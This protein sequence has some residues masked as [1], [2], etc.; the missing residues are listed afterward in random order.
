MTS[1][2]KKLNEFEVHL[3]GETMD[4]SRCEGV[5]VWETPFTTLNH[6]Q[7]TCVACKTY[8]RNP[9]RPPAFPGQTNETLNELER[10]VVDAAIKWDMG[11]RN[12]GNNLMRAVDALRAAKDEYGT[13]AYFKKHLTES[14]N[15]KA[16]RRLVALTLI[17]S[18]ITANDI[19]GLDGVREISRITSVLAALTLVNE[20]LQ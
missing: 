15:T 12:G 17:K 13:V 11:G 6:D 16:G 5:P 7:V 1:E 9:R 20:A 3:A 8:P 2:T 10:A 14:A 4:K 18:I 19:D